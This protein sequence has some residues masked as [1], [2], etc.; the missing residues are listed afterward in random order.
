[1]NI[2]QGNILKLSDNK[3]YIVISTCIINNIKYL[4]LI[5]ESDNTSLK[6]CREEDED[7]GSR[8]AFTILTNDDEI[9]KIIPDLYAN[10]M[11]D[12]KKMEEENKED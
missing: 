2:V 9:K 12:Y 7:N 5:D 3:S 4:L 6:F 11:K 8:K 10:G 1:M